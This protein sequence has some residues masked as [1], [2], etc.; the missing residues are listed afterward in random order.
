ML[1]GYANEKK[2]PAFD[3]VEDDKVV[4]FINDGH[5]NFNHRR[6][7]TTQA[8]GVM[9]IYAADLDG[10]SDQDVLSASFSDNT[11]AWYENTGRGRFNDPGSRIIS[12]QADHPSS[13]H[14]ADLDNDGDQDVLSASFTFSEG[15]IAWYENREKGSFG[16]QQIITTQTDRASLV[17][18]ADLDGDGDEDVLS[19]SIDDDKVAWYENDGNGNFSEQK[20]ITTEAKEA[21]SVFAADLDGDGDMDVLSA[22]KE[23]NKIAWYKNLMNPAPST[24]IRSLLPILITL[25]SLILLACI[26]V[27]Y[28]K[29]RNS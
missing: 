20:I 17:Y 24:T 9:S 18:V 29:R 1:S 3:I 21:T 12:R 7:I 2:A 26:G 13:V 23:D 27:I 16:P 28:M 15:K 8:D 19:A 6:I 10:D 11:I 4:C 5:G 14:A 22:S 25:T